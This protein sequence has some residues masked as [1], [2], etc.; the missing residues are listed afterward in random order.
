MLFHHQPLDHEKGKM[1]TLTV[2]A[3]NE[4]PLV[5]ALT[6]WNTIPVELSV[7][8]VDE[9]PE[10]SIPNKVIRVKENT[11]NGTVL[12]SYL[13][14]DPESKST[15]GIRYYKV[16]DPG[17]WLSVGEATG[18]LKVTNTIDLESPLVTNAMY[19]I[20]VKA[21]DLMLCEVEEK[22]GSVTLTAHD[23]DLL[24]YST[25]FNFQLSGE[26]ASEWRLRDA[27]NTSVVLEQVADMPRGDH[28]VHIRIADLQDKGQVQEVTVRV[29]LCLGGQC[30]AHRS[31]AGLGAW[32]VLALLLALL[33][34]LLLGLLFVFA[35][36]AR[37]EKMYIDDAGG[38][39]LLQSN[40]EAPGEEVKSAD[41]LMIS[42]MDGSAKGAVLD[43]NDN[44]SPGGKRV[45]GQQNLYQSSRHDFMTSAQH[46]SNFNTSMGGQYRGGGGGSHHYSDSLYQKQANLA[47]YNTWDTNKLY[48]EE[49]LDYFGGEG[50]LCCTLDA[51]HMYRYEGEGSAA[52]SVGCCSDMGDSDS[53]DF[54]DSLGPKFKTLANICRNTE[55]RD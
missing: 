38:G 1:V 29:C 53:L 7:G 4:V 45:V 5:K 51:P 8:N 39:M 11:P 40:T 50:E 54:L 2:S 20:T 37:G 15:A 9:G 49:K 17:S 6:S 43:Q 21:V 13:A 27:Q 41:L 12:G 18:E 32:G 24:P 55:D 33:A 25:P 44:V 16:S 52:G 28:K 48:L 42:T 19:N 10:F 34:L 36:N 35:C 31:S 22:R 46:Q 14:V 26:S 47:L 23:A 3:Q 30:V